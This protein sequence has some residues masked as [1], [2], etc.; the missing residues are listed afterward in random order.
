MTPQTYD[1][2]RPNWIKSLRRVE[3]GTDSN[4][5]EGREESRTSLRNVPKKWSFIVRRGRSQ[6]SSPF[7]FPPEEG[8]IRVVMI[9]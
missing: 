2:E 1:K 3:E 4:C 6:R 8:P 5:K 7:H 9:L